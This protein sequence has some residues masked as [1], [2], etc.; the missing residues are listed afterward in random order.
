MEQ[1][2]GDLYYPSKWISGITFGLATIL[3]YKSFNFLV[4]LTKVKNRSRKLKKLMVLRAK[5]QN[6][7]EVTYLIS[8]ANAHYISFI[9]MCFFF[10]SAIILSSKVNAL[11][12]QSMLF[13]LIMGTPI[14]LFEFVWLSQEMKARELVKEH[15]KLLR[16]RNSMPNTYEPPA[17]Q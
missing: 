7:M 3:V 4:K 12:E 9:M 13:G 1:L 10:L 15:G 17:C 14:L 16:Y 11:I 2:L 8:S 5:R 6:P